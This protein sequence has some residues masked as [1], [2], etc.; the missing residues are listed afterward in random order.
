MLGKMVKWISV[1]MIIALTLS[2][3]GGQSGKISESKAKETAKTV[4]QDVLDV[5]ESP[6]TVH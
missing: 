1:I 5:D 6:E 3:C 4:L 2:A